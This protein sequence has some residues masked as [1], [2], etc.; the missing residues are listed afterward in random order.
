MGGEGDA[1]ILQNVTRLVLLR[2]QM[3]STTTMD[4]HAVQSEYQL[5]EKQRKKPAANA[6]V[7]ADVASAAI[8]VDNNIRAGRDGSSCGIHV[9]LQHARGTKQQQKQIEPCKSA[10]NGCDGLGACADWHLNDNCRVHARACAP[11]RAS[12]ESWRS[13]EGWDREWSRCRH[14]KGGLKRTCRGHYA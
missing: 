2:L 7:N 6:M 3:L 4:V 14:R 1:K 12:R 5:H 11:C 9:S 8:I 13:F 10:D